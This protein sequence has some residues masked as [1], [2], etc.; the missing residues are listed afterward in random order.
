ML[1]F[2]IGKEILQMDVQDLTNQEIV[3]QEIQEFT[4]SIHLPTHACTRPPICPTIYLLSKNR[5]WVW[6]IEESNIHN[7][8]ALS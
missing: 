6:G 7:R 8:Q 1:F 4:E 3:N 2:H 5:L